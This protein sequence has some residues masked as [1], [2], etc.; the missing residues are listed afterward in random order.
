VASFRARAVVLRGVPLGEADRIVHLL[1][2]TEGKVR[3]VVKGVRRTE[4]RWGGRFEPFS[5]LSVEVYRGRSLDRV[6]Q[7]EVVEAFPALR[8]DFGRVVRASVMA[9]AVDQ[10]AL[11]GEAQ[12]ALFALLRRALVALEAGDRPMLLA[13]FLWKL[14]A[15]EGL[16]P[17]LDRCGRCG[18]P[19]DP[20]AF[21][22]AGTGL[23][24]ACCRSGVRAEPEAVGLVRLCLTGGLAE[25]LARPASLATA[26]AEA[27]A[28]A[29]LERHLERP[30]KSAA[31]LRGS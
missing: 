24:G 9:E 3:A 17:A 30:L 6:I 29:A 10:V 4:S 26:M 23:L 19:A 25:A 18:E 2:D 15:L 7:A 13:G 11:E 21:D 31:V 28:I 14:L 8:Q 22:R 12:P 27:E 20:V 16:A 1:T 5:H